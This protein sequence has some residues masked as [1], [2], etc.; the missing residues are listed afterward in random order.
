MGRLGEHCMSA[1]DSLFQGCL[2]KVE[3]GRIYASFTGPAHKINVQTRESKGFPLSMID[4]S[5]HHCNTNAPDNQL[6]CEGILLSEVL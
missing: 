2:S 4:Q 3:V 5:G 6:P 1:L